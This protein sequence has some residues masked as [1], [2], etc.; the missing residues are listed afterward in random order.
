MKRSI[1]VFMLVLVS[2]MVA[3]AFTWELRADEVV[4]L[5]ALEASADTV[6]GNSETVAD[7]Y[8]QDPDAGFIE[9]A[10]VDYSPVVTAAG[11]RLQDLGGGYA[12]KPVPVLF[13]LSPIIGA[14]ATDEPAPVKSKSYDSKSSGHSKG[15]G[16]DL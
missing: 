2:G 1:L 16:C 8:S 4:A 9:V 10:G 13:G 15:L 6:A 12:A 7:L 3:A 5:R 11:I 14:V